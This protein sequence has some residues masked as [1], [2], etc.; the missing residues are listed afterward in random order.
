[1]PAGVWG[2][3][4]QHALTKQVLCANEI[5]TEKSN[6]F[7]FSRGEGKSGFPVLFWQKR[8]SKNGPKSSFFGVPGVQNRGPG[9]SWPEVPGGPKIG[10]RGPKIPDFWGPPGKKV[11][12]GLNHLPKLHRKIHFLEG[13]F[14]GP[15]PRIFPPGTRK[16][17]ARA[18]KSRNPGPRKSQI[19]PPKS[20]FSAPE[21]PI[22]REKK[23]GKSRFS[24][25]LL[26]FNKDLIRIWPTFSKTSVFPWFCG[27]LPW[28]RK[29]G[30]FSIFRGGI[31][32]L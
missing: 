24:G 7:D 31:K 10:S 12:W 21:I 14:P 18:R 6:G 28:P 11:A 15:G 30:F 13:K 9:G 3:P 26:I 19:S 5:S 17:P 25:F 27:G 23:G 16:F 2:L 29:W 20:R 22:F 1:M 32:I 4:P 8:G